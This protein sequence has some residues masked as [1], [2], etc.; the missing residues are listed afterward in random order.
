MYLVHGA[1]SY[2]VARYRVGST[3][4]R[5]K[6]SKVHFADLARGSKLNV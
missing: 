3:M 6:F 5:R 4:P 2:D 1:P